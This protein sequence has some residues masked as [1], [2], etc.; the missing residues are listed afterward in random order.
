MYLCRALTLQSYPAI[1]RHLGGRDHSTIIAGIHKIE[2][3]IAADPE[4]AARVEQI[5]KA[6][7]A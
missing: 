4:F 6:I 2:D 5:R 7:N 1:G 3:R